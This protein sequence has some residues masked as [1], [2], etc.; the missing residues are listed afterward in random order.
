[1]RELRDGVLRV[2][3]AVGGFFGS[4]EEPGGDAV[5]A[6]WVTLRALVRVAR[7]GGGVTRVCGCEVG[8]GRRGGA[9]A[10]MVA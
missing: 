9:G 6:G 3:T 2:A 4:S 7:E 10:G 8:V 5:E 1:M